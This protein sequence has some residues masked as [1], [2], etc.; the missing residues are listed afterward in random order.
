M[1]SDR[2]YARAKH[3]FVPQTGSEIPLEVGD[4]LLIISKEDSGWWK[5]KVICTQKSNVGLTGYFP[6]SYTV[7]ASSP[8]GKLKA[9]SGKETSIDEHDEKVL[10]AFNATNNVQLKE[11]QEIIDKG[12]SELS[13]TMK[14]VPRAPIKITC[15]SNTVG[16]V[17]SR[18]SNHRGG[19]RVY[20]YDSTTTMM[21][22]DS[23]ISKPN[24]KASIRRLIQSNSINCCGFL[25]I[26]LLICSLVSKGSKYVSKFD[27][28]EKSF[29][30]K[31]FK[32]QVE[33]EDEPTEESI[34]EFINIVFYDCQLEVSD[35]ESMWNCDFAKTFK[36]QINQKKINEWEALF[37]AGIRFN[38]VV[39]TSEYTK[40]YFLLREHQQQAKIQ[41]APLNQTRAEELEAL[42][43]IALKR[44]KAINFGNK[45][46][47]ATF[48]SCKMP[49]PLAIFN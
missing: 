20:K 19:K 21:T 46:R 43:T 6:G 39:S 23:T 22:V 13:Q 17:Q 16:P 45:R 24:I 2:A 35:D 49:S 28:D 40:L 3:K 14:A 41:I 42:S 5:G 12:C 38:V 27:E 26:A 10:I 33:K 11:D 7:S 32:N 8:K 30:H 36:P 4:I 47:A 18:K 37:L 1:A 25:S 34:S 15:Q 31:S 44:L 29:H 48:D 9:S